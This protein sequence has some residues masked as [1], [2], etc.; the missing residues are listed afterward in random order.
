MLCRAHA[1]HLQQVCTEADEVGPRD[2]VV[3]PCAAP[4]RSSQLEGCS[5]RLE[6]SEELHR[7]HLAPARAPAPR[8]AAAAAAAADSKQCGGMP[9]PRHR[10]TPRRRRPL[11]TVLQAATLLEAALPEDIARVA[12]EPRAVEPRAADRDTISH[13]DATHAPRQGAKAVT[14]FPLPPLLLERPLPPL[15]VLAGPPSLQRRPGGL[16]PPSCELPSWQ[17]RA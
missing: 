14:S 6:L 15:H 12:A 5:R 1:A 4:A 16:L 17:R 11:R 3:A 2:H 9:R 8:R 10:Q 13:R 7:I